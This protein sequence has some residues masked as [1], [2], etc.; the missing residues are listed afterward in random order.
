LNLADV[1]FQQDRDLAE[2]L[3][4]ESLRIRTLIYGSNHQNVGQ[5]SILLALIL[6]AQGKLGDET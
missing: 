2:E 6:R 3:A 5:C 1:I 4:R